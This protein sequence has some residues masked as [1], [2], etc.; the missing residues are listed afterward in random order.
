MPT[1]I[2]ISGM[3]FTST[4]TAIIASGSATDK[5][6]A[7]A[8]SSAVHKTAYEYAEYVTSVVDSATSITYYINANTLADATIVL[9][10]SAS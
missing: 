6:K 5:A 3:Q 8:A 7:S 9:S 10:I 2:L 4:L 1:D